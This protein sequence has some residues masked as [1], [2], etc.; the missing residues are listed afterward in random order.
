MQGSRSGSLAY[1]HGQGWRHLLHDEG[2]K[3]HREGSAHESASRDGWWLVHQDRLYSTILQNLLPS[4]RWWQ[5][6]HHGRYEEG[7]NAYSQLRNLQLEA[8]SDFR[9]LWKWWVRYCLLRFRWV[10]CFW[11]SSSRQW[12]AILLPDLC[13][14]R[15]PDLGFWTNHARKPSA[16][17]RTSLC[18]RER[19][20]LVH[21]KAHFDKGDRSG[22]W[23]SWRVDA[24]WP[25]AWQSRP[26]GPRP[27]RSAPLP[28]L[29]YRDVAARWPFLHRYSTPAWWKPQ[30][31]YHVY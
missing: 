22:S 24:G 25:L 26:L 15:Q 29:Q 31:L 3:W 28:R 19:P 12:Q 20:D 17:Q 14:L 18:Q 4:L 23:K 2:F 30:Q 6:L 9:A 1:D 8:N 10:D 13:Q 16:C 21:A 27:P 5:V 11:W 7:S